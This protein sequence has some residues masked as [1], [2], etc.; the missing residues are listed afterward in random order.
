MSRIPQSLRATIARN[1]RECRREKFP[2]RGGSKKCAEKFSLYSGKNISPQQWS[3]WESGRRTPNEEYLQQIAAFF[4]KTVE[5]ML[6]DNSQPAPPIPVMPY[7]EPA[8]SSYA[9][10]SAPELIMAMGHSRMKGVYQVEI[11]V[12]SVKFVPCHEQSD[13]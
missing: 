13:S 7:N 10:M 3:P 12:A 1:I 6:R 4:E 2:G 8:D 9:S 5:Y 11:S